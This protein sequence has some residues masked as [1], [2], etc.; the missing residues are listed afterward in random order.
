M[1]RQLQGSRIVPQ[2][3]AAPF[4]HHTPVDRRLSRTLSFSQTTT[5]PAQNKKA[6]GTMSSPTTPLSRSFS[7][8]SLGKALQKLRSGGSAGTGP[9]KIACT[10]KHHRSSLFEG[11]SLV[12][13]S[14]SQSL[15]HVQAADPSTNVLRFLAV[16]CPDDVLPKILAYA[17]P[18]TTYALS[19]VNRDWRQI[20]AREV[21]WQVLCEELYKV[22]LA[23]IFLVL[24]NF[25]GKHLSTI[26][27]TNESSIITRFRS[28]TFDT[29]SRFIF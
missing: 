12:A 24:L 7:S 6:R 2:S 13:S 9:G 22:R 10:H 28:N 23:T 1:V 26:L 15:S 8:S 11:G 4:E 18:Q 25:K 17:G 5:N 14:T 19:R 3:A 20:V 29:H 16:S 21:T 27:T